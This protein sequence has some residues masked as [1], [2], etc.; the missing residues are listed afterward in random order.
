L[1]VA[2]PA[3]RTGSE[4]EPGS[5]R[6]ILTGGRHV[7]R[8]ACLSGPPV[9]AGA[10]SYYLAEVNIDEDADWDFTGFDGGA[11]RMRGNGPDGHG[12]GSGVSRGYDERG[13]L[14]EV[15]RDHRTGAALGPDYRNP[16]REYRLGMAAGTS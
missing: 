2:D 3:D 6:Q 11:L 15:R 9:C 16:G 5:E 7:V 10:L 14:P 12:A 1:L 8:R 13:R 4:S